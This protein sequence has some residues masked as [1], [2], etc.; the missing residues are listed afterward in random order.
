MEAPTI[1]GEGLIFDLSGDPVVNKSMITSTDI[2]ATYG[3]VHVVD[4]VLV[5]SDLAL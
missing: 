2:K 4:T 3:I 5:P 1:N